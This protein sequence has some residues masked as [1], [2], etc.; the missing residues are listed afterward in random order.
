MC[1]AFRL[2]SYICT[3]FTAAKIKAHAVSFRWYDQT[4]PCLGC[5][6]C[7]DSDLV[8]SI[9]FGNEHLKARLVM[10]VLVKENLKIILYL[11]RE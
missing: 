3:L 2:Y 6:D 7:Q 10:N 1:M 11:K 4:V 5:S 9:L 8:A